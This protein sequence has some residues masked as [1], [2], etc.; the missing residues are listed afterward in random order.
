VTVSDGQA[1]I[2]RSV[3]V[4]VG[5]ANRA[6]TVV[7]SA[8][9]TGGV[10]PLT[11]AFSATGTDAD[12]DALTYAW[13]FGDGGTAEGASASHTFAAAG[14]YSVT[15]TVKD[16]KGATGSAVLTVVADAA[17]GASGNP[18]S[19]ILRPVAPAS[20]KAFAK[21][22]VKVGLRC[23][24]AGKGTLSARVSKQVAK[25]LKLPGRVLA[26]GKVTCVAGKT[27][28]SRIKPSRKVR[29]ALIAARAKSLKFTLRLVLPGQDAVERTLTVR[30]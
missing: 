10:A 14:S 27:V 7:A 9:P 17:P 30:R 2:S 4:T 15:V 3:T 12:G 18:P 29:K 23:P 16:A 20:I 21:N 5:Q 6:P 26:T 11:V 24:S 22:G 25:R 1:S 8:D 19:V 13:S 28:S